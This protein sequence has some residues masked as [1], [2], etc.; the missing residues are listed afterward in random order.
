[1][2]LMVIKDKRE[3]IQES[4]GN[5]EQIGNNNLTC[6]RFRHFVFLILFVCQWDLK[7]KSKDCLYGPW[8]VL[9]FLLWFVQNNP[10][11]LS[12]VSSLGRWA[13]AK[14]RSS[15]RNIRPSCCSSFSP[16]TPCWHRNQSWRKIHRSLKNGVE[17]GASSKMLIPSWYQSWIN[18]RVIRLI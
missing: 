7:N 16:E 18:T 15:S 9:S 5:T 14:H 3:E 11:P 17:T 2:W 4:L 8:A 13:E 10:E 6:K 12:A 1:M